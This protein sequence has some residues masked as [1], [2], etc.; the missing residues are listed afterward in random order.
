MLLA[1]QMAWGTV[2]EVEQSCFRSGIYR[3]IGM[4]WLAGFMEGCHDQGELHIRQA[5]GIS[6]A[7]PLKQ[8]NL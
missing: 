8:T 7:Y 3:I 4:P 1:T 5:L 2:N 6:S